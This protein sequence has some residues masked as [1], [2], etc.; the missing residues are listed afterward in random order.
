MHRLLSSRSGHHLA[1]RFS[2]VVGPASRGALASLRHSSPVARGFSST[3]L[4]DHTVQGMPA[5]SPT[6]EVGNVSW[7]M[8]VSKN[9]YLLTNWW[10]NQAKDKIALR[11]SKGVLAIEV[12]NKLLKATT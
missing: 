11:S 3:D 2:G 9:L 12:V 10:R 8:E 4:P 6:M 1:L 7:R 5:L